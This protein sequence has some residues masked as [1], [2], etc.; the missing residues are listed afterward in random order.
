MTYI[1]EKILV[2]LLLLI[3]IGNVQGETSD[4]KIAL[5]L[6]GGGAKGFAHIGVLKVLE[7]EGIPIDIIV[8]TSVGSIVGGL[9]SIGYSAT[10]IE[11]MAK[12]QNWPKLLSDVIPRRYLST[13]DKAEKQRYIISLPFNE[14]KKLTL[15]KSLVNGQNVLNLFCGLA[16]NVPNNADFSSF[17]ISFACIGTDLETG[18]EVVID[19]GFL[20][21]AIFSSMAIPGAFLPGEH[22]GRTMIDGGIVNN[23]PTDVAKKMGAD[24][25]IGVDI[26]SKL[27]TRDEIKSMGDMFNQLLSFYTIEKD[28]INNSICDIVIRPDMTG[29]NPASFSDKAVDTLINRGMASTY[30]VIDEIRK[31]KSNY[32]LSKTGESRK[33]IMP[34]RWLIKGITLSGKYSLDDKLLINTLSLEVPGSYSHDK[35]K[36]AIDKLYGYGS[37]SQIYYN[38]IEEPD[39]NIL[40]LTL[41]GKRV[42]KLNI[43]AKLNS[44]DAMAVMLN[45]TKKDYRRAIGLLSIS[46]E[47]S[48]NPGGSIL[49]EIRKKNLP[50]IGV[51]IKGKYRRYD[52]Y[53]EEE[54]EYSTDLF[55]LSGSAYIYKSFRNIV[56]LGAGIKQEY[57]NGDVFTRNVDEEPINIRNEASITNYFAYLS[58]DNLD[59]YYFPT[60]GVDFYSEFSF[61]DNL[62]IGGDV[63]PIVLVRM[64]SIIPLSKNLSLLVN[65]YGR[66][67]FNEE[68][69]DYKSNIAGGEYHSLYFDNHLP[70]LGIPPIIL[71]NQHAFI[72]Y[73]GLRVN[74]AKVHYITVAGNFLAHN[75]E[76]DNFDTYETVWGGGITYSVKSGLGPL[77]FTLGFSD[78]YN[79]PTFSVNL[80]YWF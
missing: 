11:T 33:L 36:D 30:G 77:E 68:G 5:V 51:E 17:P 60:K 13:T 55:Y 44:T 54:K 48:S 8:G 35:I 21:T 32:I 38:L 28:S 41:K 74:I 29:Y 6:S 24:I 45:A 34:E 43:G 26:S 67:I 75:N 76:L 66:S 25:I 4:P 71:L 23:F 50:S 14:Q 53:N 7:E 49:A 39:G 18:K 27:F 10:E 56:N 63:T 58:M 12:E 72:A 52:I 78:Y 47:I 80:G 73:S 9:Y 61:A 37:F 69:T 15:P 57:F 20:P 1:K 16:G 19:N 79:K 3:T 70:F 2:F 42:A 31:I 62:N 40:N 65:L 64:R 22:N 46:A 59:D